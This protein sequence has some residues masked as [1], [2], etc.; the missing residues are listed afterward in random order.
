[1]RRCRNTAS[2]GAHVACDGRLFQ[3]WAGNWKSPF[4]DGG[5]VERRDSKLTGRSRSESPPGWHVS[6]TG[7]VRRQI[8]WCTAVQS[9]V[10][11]YG[12]LEQDAFRNAKPVKANE[13]V[14]NMLGTPYP[15]N[16]PCCRLCSRSSCVVSFY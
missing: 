7:E 9:S 11:R 5:K 16:E 15:V 6:D 3:K 1:M 2:D 13:R 10:G 4:S 14:C 12:D 8:R